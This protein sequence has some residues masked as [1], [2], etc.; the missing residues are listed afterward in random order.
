MKLTQELLKKYL[1]YDPDTGIF[2][3]LRRD[4]S[5]FNSDKAYKKWH[6]DRLGKEAGN[7]GVK[8]IK[9]VGGKKKN[10]G[11][12]KRINFCKFG[13]QPILYH[14]LAWLYMTGKWPS[15]HIDHIDGNRLNNRFDNLRDVPAYINYRNSKL[16][17]NNNS[18]CSGV[19]YVKAAKKWRVDVPS[20]SQ[21]T[22]VI[23]IGLFAA[24]EEAILVRK[25]YEQEMQ[26]TERHGT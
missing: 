19:T 22:N 7:K 1:H 2:T 13:R 14:R 8:D 21:Y 5:E 4:R 18:G 6:D 20:G 12:Y 23:Y 3:W 9:V 10:Y 16:Y 26:F 25:S 15:H 11:S 24:K 17:S